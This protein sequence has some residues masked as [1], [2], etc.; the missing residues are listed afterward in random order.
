MGG[1]IDQLGVSLKDLVYPRHLWAPLGA[2]DAVSCGPGVV[3]PIVF[4]GLQ[5]LRPARR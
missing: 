2:W 1:H 4:P 3:F 5:F